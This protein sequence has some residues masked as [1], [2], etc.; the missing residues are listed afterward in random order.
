MSYARNQDYTDKL[1]SKG[2]HSKIVIQD[3][4]IRNKAVYLHVLRRR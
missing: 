1:E 3:F 4:P 2:F